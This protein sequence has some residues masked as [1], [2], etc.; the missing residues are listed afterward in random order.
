[1]QL[2]EMNASLKGTVRSGGFSHGEKNKEEE[3]SFSEKTKLE[4]KHKTAFRYCRCQSIGIDVHHIIPEKD[5]GS[6]D[7]S[8]AAPLCQNC[9]D[10]F[11]G[12]PEKR[13]EITQ[14]RDWWYE[15]CGEMFSQPGHEDFLDKLR[16]I[17]EKIESIQDSQLGVPELKDMLKGIS[18]KLIDDITPETA[19]TTAS[20][21]INATTTT[22]LGEG[23]YVSFKE[24][25]E[26]RHKFLHRIYEL[27]RE[28]PNEHLNAY[29]IGKE[30]GFSP[31]FTTIVMNSLN[32]EGKIRIKGSHGASDI[33]QYG[34]EQ[35]EKD[36]LKSS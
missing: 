12:N 18:I 36:L 25:I 31:K 20:G 17:N 19:R 35:V 7:I 27:R 24:E 16:Q 22:T 33:T 29:D 9:H 4:V 1:M 11:G 23:V 2:S 28:K 14:M 3:M 15:K 32:R 30:L 6:D 13:K 10:Q 26:M 21:I 8:N 5:S 34:I